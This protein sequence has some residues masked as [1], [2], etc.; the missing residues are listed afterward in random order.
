MIFFLLSYQRLQQFQYQ[1]VL[2]ELTILYSTPFWIISMYCK[3]IV[4]KGKNL[5]Y[6]C[7]RSHNVT[8]LILKLQ[9]LTIILILIYSW[10]LN[11]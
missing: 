11:L 10:K 9:D 6:W 7:I 3:F 4:D 1:I 2:K 5:N 8:R